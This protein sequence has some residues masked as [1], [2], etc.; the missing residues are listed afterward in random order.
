MD[1]AAVGLELRDLELSLHRSE[2][3]HSR[4]RVSSLLADDFVEFGSS[5]RVYNKTTIVELMVHEQDRAPPPAV[6]DFD[7]RFLSPEVALITYRAV[8]ADRKTLRSSIW[9]LEGGSWCMA[10]HQGTPA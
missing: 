10:F 9:R 7:V 1:Q 8:A 2:V 6:Y 3:R 5:G 4:E